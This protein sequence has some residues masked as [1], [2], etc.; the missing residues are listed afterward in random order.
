VVRG[1]WGAGIAAR[2]VTTPGGFLLPLLLGIIA[3][4]SAVLTT[5]DVEIDEDRL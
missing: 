5:A 2:R 1:T 4:I 3:V